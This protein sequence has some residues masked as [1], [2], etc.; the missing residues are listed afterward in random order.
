[1]F[2][3]CSI[4]CVCSKC[5]PFSCREVKQ[6]KA[7]DYMD[8]YEC[9]DCSS[10]KSQINL[11]GEPKFIFEISYGGWTNYFEAMEQVQVFLL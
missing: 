1:M 2:F 10:D 7:N 8:P 11:V 6:W 4:K 3:V 5:F 9:D